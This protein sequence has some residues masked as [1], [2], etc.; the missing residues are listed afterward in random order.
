MSSN[1]RAR[2]RSW[3]R[4]RSPGRSIIAALGVAALAGASLLSVT[5]AAQAE[6][7]TPGVPQANT[8]VFEEDFENGPGTTPQLLSA[9]TGANG[10]TYTADAVWLTACN[11]T[12]VNFAIPFTDLGNCASAGNSSNLRQLAYALGVHGGAGDPNTN[13]VVA[14]YTEGNP[15]A[16]AI[17]FQ[18]VDN[19]ALASASGR[20]LTF[21]VDTAAVNCQVSAPQYQ[22][23]FLDDEGAAT[24]VGGV[25]NACSSGTTVTAP[26]VGALPTR[27]VSVGTYT[28]NGS[29]L[30]DGSSL[31]IRMTNANGS[32]TGNDAAFDNIRIL[33]VTP[34][35]DKSFSP[36]SLVAEEVSTLTLT[37]TNTDD[38]AAKNGWSFVDELPTGLTIAD[39]SA[40]TTCPA[41]VVD[42]PVGG[43]TITASGDLTAGMESC[44]VTV[45]VTSPVAGTFTN[46]PDNITS[47]GLNDPADTTVEF[48]EQEPA[49]RVVKSATPTSEEEFVLGQNVTYSFVVTNTGNVTLTDV[50]VSEGEFSGTGELSDVVCPVGAS[51][52]APGASVTCTATYEVTQ[53]DVDAGSITNAATATGTPPNGE[54]PVSPESEVTIPSEEPAP[55]LTIDKEADVETITAAGETIEYSFLVTNTGNVTLTDVVV[56]EG[57]FSGTGELS[58]V[59]CPAGAS[60]LAPG[61][62]VTCTA[63]YD[64]TQEDVDAGSITNAATATGTP[65]NPVTPPPV[66]PSDEVTVDVPAAPALTIDKEADVETIT[67]AG[68]TIEYSFLVTNTGNVTLTD[69][70][71][72]EGEFSGTGELSDVVCPAGAS[73][74]APGASVTCTA[75]YDVTQEDVDAGSITNAATATGTPPNPVTPPPVSPSDDVTVDIPANPAITVV[76]SADEA[77][78]ADIAVGQEITYSFLVTNTGNVTLADVVVTEGEFSGAGDLS[79]I[80]CPDDASRLAP[81]GQITCTATYTVVQADVD[82]GTVTNTATATGTPPTGEAPVSPESE[83]TVPSVPAPGLDVVKTAS[84][85]R[86]NT[87]GQSITY[88]FLVTNTGNL[89]LS[90]ITV[91]E[92]EFTGTGALSAIACPAGA[93]SLAPGAQVTCTATYT[94]TQ[95]DLDAGSI[96]N[97]ATAGGLTPGGEPFASDPSTVTVDTPGT[98]LATTGGDLAW[99]IAATGMLLLVGGGALL[100]VRRRRAMFSD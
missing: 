22:F 43:T 40:A 18:T 29:V 2:L 3:S 44:T 95:A 99:G 71:V 80:V 100:V 34:Q 42:A 26:A 49:I 9:Y 67:A 66:S 92:E 8:V 24:N 17:E 32:G 75:T 51:S 28:S 23:S 25:L 33:D 48:V 78:H 41:G 31:G 63:T 1:R 88:S 12:I 35:L 6:P 36:A 76:K 91:D 39:G 81:A 5:T 47:T 98:P 14:A 38:L 64:L 52:L 37:V 77:A 85:E 72:S 27:A 62:S 50:V 61:A 55:A 73:S 79:E 94:V 59:V 10:Q 93:E 83:V 46:G 20:F 58:D 90:D 84:V 4:R 68:E 86:A 96:S 30:F 65:P 56:S 69:V 89:T 57:E 7:G 11:G 87:V 19:I 54:P 16:G 70:V 53:E 82:A 15:G 13:D 97:T 45:N 21:S 60:S 74:L